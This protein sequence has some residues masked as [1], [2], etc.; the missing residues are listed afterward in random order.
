[1]CTGC[2]FFSFFPFVLAFCSA[3][4]LENT[5]N[6]IMRLSV[7]LFMKCGR[8]V[9]ISRRLV[10]NLLTFEALVINIT[11]GKS[12]K[13]IQ[14]HF[15][16]NVF[17]FFL[18]TDPIP[19]H[20]LSLALCLNE[21]PP[22]K[23]LHSPHY[24]KM[25]DLARN[26][27]TLGQPFAHVTETRPHRVT[28]LPPLSLSLSLELSRIETRTLFIIPIRVVTRRACIYIYSRS[29]QTKGSR[30]DAAPDRR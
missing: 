28:P 24:H 17:P 10:N 13:L 12:Y 22:R 6:A 15:R 16:V 4:M 30:N 8:L 1:M 20:N 3:P 23:R 19:L 21:H 27:K 29:A 25:I 9:L 14:K 18:Y 7:L 5:Q 2:T 26:A 11:T